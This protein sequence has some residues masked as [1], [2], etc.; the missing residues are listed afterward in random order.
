MVRS[1]LRKAG[2]KRRHRDDM[3]N[4]LVIGGSYFAGRVF[5]ETLRPLGEHRIYAFNRGNIPI[6]LEG[7]REIKGDREKPAQ[8]AAQIPDRAWDAV[9]DFCAYIPEHITG[10]LEHLTGTIRHYILI[11]TTSVYVP[12]APTPVVESAPKLNREQPE[13]GPFAAYGVDKWR[14][15]RA[16]AAECAT[17]DIAWTV[18]RPAIIYGRYNYAPRESYL[19]DLVTRREPLI[20]PEWA[21]ARFSFVWVEDLARVIIRALNHTA[22]FSQAYNIAGPEA[23]SYAELVEIV[24]QV[25][26][27]RLETRIAPQ[28]VGEEPMTLPFPPDSDLLYDGRK[29]QQVLGFDYTPFEEAMAQTWRYYQRL[30]SRKSA[31]LKS[32]SGIPPN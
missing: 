28:G 13:L 31:A 32:E 26:G 30:M 5:I 23:V 7:V 27:E 19:F 14:T 20:L 3:K 10:M 17:R 6:G 4:I 12:E 8:I 11:S 22:L 18:L 9:V 21:P 25:C 2:T 1:S 16:L 15:E 29:I 24:S